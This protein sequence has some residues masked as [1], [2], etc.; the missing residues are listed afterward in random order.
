MI[1]G[2][3][4]PISIRRP[5]VVIPGVVAFP[6]AKEST[7]AEGSPAHVRVA[8]GVPGVVVVHEILGLTPHIRGLTTRF[9]SEGFAALAPDL[10]VRDGPPPDGRSVSDIRRFARGLPDARVVADITAALE[11]LAEQPGVDRTRCAVVGFCYGGTCALHVAA[12]DAPI[13]AA[14]VFY[15]KA[16]YPETSPARP[17]SPIDRVPDIRVPV[18]AHYGGADAAIPQEE[19]EALRDALARNSPLHELHV[20]AGAGH[21][22]FNDARPQLY[23][24]KA[25]A[26]AWTRTLDFLR[27]WLEV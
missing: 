24:A 22:F 17:T 7:A 19:V 20:Y 14:V 6:E 25:A 10:F 8:Y 15:G 18:L 26:L 5:D 3:P 13:K 2:E 4:R 16:I 12:S 27:H 11:T 21:A 9:A 23:H 1:D